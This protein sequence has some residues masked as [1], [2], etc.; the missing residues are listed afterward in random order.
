MALE[1]TVNKIIELVAE[2]TKRDVDDV[3]RSDKWGEYNFDECRDDLERAYS[4][5]RPLPEL[6]LESI[7]QANAGSIQKQLGA[8]N[9][10]INNAAEFSVKTDNA[11]HERDTLAVALSRHAQATWTGIAPWIGYLFFQADD[12]TEGLKKIR[13]SQGHVDNELVSFLK[14]KDD[15][16]A[17]IENAVTAAK[18]IAGKAGVGHFT[19]DFANEAKSHNSASIK[20]LVATVVFAVAAGSVAYHFGTAQQVPEEVAAILQY[21]TMRIVILG[22][23]FTGTVWCG[24]MYKTNKHQQSIN[25]HRANALQTFQ[26]FVE[27]TDDPAIRDAVL[28]ET[29]RSIFTIAPSGYL[30][31]IDK[32]PDAGSRIVQ[33]IKAA[34]KSATED[35]G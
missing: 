5:I 29:T 32:S 12:A 20:W 19:E 13:E 10:A 25:K 33:V 31:E 16:L 34:S 35:K 28:M 27:A 14:K 23:L 7:L 6:P 9:T 8:L 22:L 4:V 21:T 3:V 24:R 17:Q 30:G 2:I 26:A 11:A 15:G 18:E 1:D